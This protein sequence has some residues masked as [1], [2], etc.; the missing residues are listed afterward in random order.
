MLKL[1]LTITGEQYICSEL[2]GPMHNKLIS[3]LGLM[4]VLLA[5]SACASIIAKPIK[6]TIELVSV[7]PLNVS[8]TSQKLRFDLRVVNPNAFDMP[9]EAVDFIARFND[10]NIASGKSNQAVTIAANSEAIVSLDV[11]CLLYTSPSPRD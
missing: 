11:T 2:T 9:I 7:K 1:A 6:P 5:L 10:T 8:L 4:I 3:R